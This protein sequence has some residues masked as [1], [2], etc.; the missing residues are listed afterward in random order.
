MET[1]IISL[2]GSIVAPDAPDTKMIAEFAK[3][4]RKFLAADD[5]RR[6]ILILLICFCRKQRTLCAD[7]WFLIQDFF[8]EPFHPWC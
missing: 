8:T 3:T 5:N 1:K 7:I 6:L 2:G 4:I